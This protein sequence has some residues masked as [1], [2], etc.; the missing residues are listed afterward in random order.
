MGTGVAQRREASAA[1]SAVAGRDARGG[2]APKPTPSQRGVVECCAV[3][4]EVGSERGGL[5]GRVED[6]ACRGGALAGVVARVVPA[7]AVGVRVGA[8]ARREE[9]LAARVAVLDGELLELDGGVGEDLI[10]VV[11]FNSVMDS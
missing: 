5:L 2:A 4:E 9:A 8:A 1:A 7:A 3:E 6:R 10:V 11:V